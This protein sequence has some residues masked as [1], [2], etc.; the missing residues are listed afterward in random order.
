M[1]I[2]AKIFQNH[3]NPCFRGV[4]SYD[5]SRFHEYTHVAN[6]D[7]E[8]TKEDLLKRS[9]TTHLEDIFHAGNYQETE[10]QFV[11]LCQS[12]SMSVG[13]IVLI[14]EIAFICDPYDWTRVS[15]VPRQTLGD[16]IRASDAFNRSIEEA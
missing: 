4:K 11:R 3:K 7:I 14:G 10:D 2:T 13:D 1:K 9:L 12:R 6:M 16:M 5:P 15:I 8:V